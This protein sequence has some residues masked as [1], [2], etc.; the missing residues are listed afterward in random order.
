MDITSCYQIGLIS[1]PHGLKGEVTILLQP[2]VPND[3][4][5]VETVFVHQNDHLVPY[6]IQTISVKGRKAYVK[7]DEVDSIEQAQAI[8]KSG[9][10]LP[11]SE[12]PALAPGDFYKD[13]ILGFEVED[14]EAGRLGY[15][16]DIIQSGLQRLLQVIHQEK[17]ILIPVDGPFITK[18]DTTK[19]KISVLLPP[20]FLE[21]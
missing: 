2:D 10:Y 16:D 5:A 12:R 1:K 20:G 11:K 14:V 21:L 7:F 13:E 6:F 17:E 18:I 4:S 9:L 8:A 15:V 19:K 3:L